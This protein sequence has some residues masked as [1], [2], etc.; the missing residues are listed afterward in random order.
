MSEEKLTY[1]E[2]KAGYEVLQKQATRSLIIKQELIHARDSLDRDLTRFRTIQT[3]SEKAI[4]AGSLEEFAEITVESIIETFELE[5]S[6]LLTYDK[7]KNS[8]KVEA[9]FGFEELAAGYPLD[10][11]WLGAKGFLKGDSAFIEKIAPDTHPWGYLGLCQVILCPYD[12]SKDDLQGFLLGGRTERNQ[13][14]Y[15]EITQEMIPSFMVFTQEMSI[16]LQ[17][18]RSKEYLERTVQERTKELK[19]TNVE[20][21]KTNEDLQQEIT[22]RTQTE[23]K[24]RLAEQE[25][26]EL[27]EFLKKMFGRYLSTEV[28]D[29]LLE[30]PSALELGGER[31]NVTI[32][33]SDL[34][35]FTSLSERLEPEQ[36]VKMLNGYFEVMVDVIHQYN[37][38]INEIIGDSLLVI[39]GAPQEIPDRAQHAIACALS[40]ENAMAKVNKENRKAGLPELEMGIGLH[41]TE[42]IVGNIGSS[43]RIKYSVVGRGVNMASRIESYTVGGQILISESVRKEAGE[44][45]RIDAQREVLPKG[46]ETPLR[47]Y[48]VGGIAGRYNLALEEKDLA[49]VTLTQKVP[50][51]YT[52][53]EGKHV[54]KKGLEGLLVRLSKKCAEIAFEEPVELLTNLKM[55]LGGVY[56]EL[57]VKDFYAKVIERS[58]KDG[59]SYLVRFTSVPPEV[60]SYFQAHQQHAVKPSAS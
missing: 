41:D 43:K 55:N 8:L 37:G 45:L 7:T 47:I 24:L 30:N 22:M 38:T 3:Y 42:V 53:L 57:A 54:G 10:I 34:R 46:S 17:N 48:E 6:A 28:M 20:L 26:T 27:S 4:H 16:L 44:V 13:A 58:G 50:L 39:F 52:I 33:M 23:E 11:D 31:R 19:T 1:N 36:V 5:C 60:A 40:M 35:G 56:E 49:L 2:L 32:M 51:W 18:L 21:K 15:N 12:D 9:A 29:S 14:Y 59:H 25:A